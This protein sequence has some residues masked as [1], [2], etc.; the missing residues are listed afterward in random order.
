MVV[1]SERLWIEN[2]E[3]VA[4]G[5]DAHDLELCLWDAFAPRAAVARVKRSCDCRG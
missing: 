3:A 1:Q 2:P 5:I 4:L